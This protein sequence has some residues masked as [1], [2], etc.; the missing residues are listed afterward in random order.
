MSA[1]CKSSP[2]ESHGRGNHNVGSLHLLLENVLATFGSD[3]FAERRLA[4]DPHSNTAEEFEIGKESR[5]LK[6]DTQ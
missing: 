2:K 5:K 3:V 4:A 1:P 6:E